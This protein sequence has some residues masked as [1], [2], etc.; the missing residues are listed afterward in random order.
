M[1]SL[2]VSSNPIKIY[3]ANSIE[4]IGV[5]VKKEYWKFSIV[6]VLLSPFAAFASKPLEYVCTPDDA[7]TQ[8]AFLG[9]AFKVSVSEDCISLYNLEDINRSW[10]WKVFSRD[11]M[12]NKEGSRHFCD[13]KDSGWIGSPAIWRQSELRLT[14]FSEKRLPN[15]FTCLVFNKNN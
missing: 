4:N 9:K 2:N 8:L 6:I 7:A 15:S 10:S 12:G 11:S 14:A 5:C 13:K 3:L 1:K